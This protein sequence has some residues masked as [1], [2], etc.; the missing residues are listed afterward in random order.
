MEKNNQI[1]PLSKPDISDRE[2]KSVLEV[3]RT[4]YLSMG[5][6]LVE[7]EEK[8]ANYL[9]IKHAIAVNSGTSG[10]HLSIRCLQIGEGD[11]VFT[12]PF[13]FVASANCI[14][15]ERATP[16]FVDI[17]E[18]T[19]NIDHSKIMDYINRNCYSSSGNL[20]DRKT[21]KKVKAI[22]P[23]HVFG[24]PC[25]MAEIKKI[26]DKYKLYIIEDAC[27]AIGAEINGQKVGTLGNIGVFAFYPNKQ[28]TTGEGGM[29]VTNDDSIAETCKCLRNQGRGNNGAWL[30]HEQ[31]GFN[32]RICDINCA[33]GIAQLSRIE[34]MLEK[35]SRVAE[36][37]NE[38]LNGIIEKQKTRLNVKKSW[39]VYIV[40]LPSH[41]TKKDRDNILY[42]L[43]ENNIGC[44]NYFPPIH[45][46]PFYQQE[47]GYE[48]GDFP[49]TESVSERTI[50][51]PFHN[52]LTAPEIDSVVGCLINLLA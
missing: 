33:L 47:F 12:T 42:Q 49:I 48:K 9:G 18:N 52:N 25:E 34:E 14:L 36:L 7:F 27:E 26:A 17:E 46:Q 5:P 51:L 8:F 1:I 38:K 39:F 37:Y 11:A 45:L 15:F 35:R 23:V 4:P 6:K 19:F 41:Y 24:Q 2:I 40:C 22:L 3:L 43:S 20:F 21:D 10:L 32:Y 30:A 44:N 28:M 16:I 29:I 50:A 31:L 13:S